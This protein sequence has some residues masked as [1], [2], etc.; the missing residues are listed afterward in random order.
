[1]EFLRQNQGIFFKILYAD[2]ESVTLGNYFMFMPLALLLSFV[3]AEWSKITRVLI[4][5]CLSGSIEVAQLII[6]GRNSELVD[7][8][9]NVFGGFLVILIYDFWRSRRN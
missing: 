1:L 6:P 4:I 3:K 7:F 2:S 9:S 5:V 8:L